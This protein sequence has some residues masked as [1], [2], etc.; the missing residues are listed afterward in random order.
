MNLLKPFVATFL[1]ASLTVSA[2]T[3][4]LLTEAQPPYAEQ[5]GGR[6]SGVA[7][8]I[9]SKLFKDVGLEY[10]VAIMPWKRAYATAQHFPNSCV[11]PVQRS[12]E[13]E[14]Q[15]HW[16]SPILITLTAFFTNADSTTSIRTLN[17]VAKLRIGSYL[18]SATA[19][20][21]QS[22]GFHVELTIRDEQNIH[23]LRRQRIDVWAT[24]ILVAN[25]LLRQSSESDSIKQRLAF[26]STLRGIACNKQVPIK[27]INRL[28]EQLKQM[29]LDG[30]IEAML[31]PYTQM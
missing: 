26:F 3:Y 27:V 24:D 28:S 5:S 25:Y 2:Q 18:G 7:V 22:Q 30:T 20:Y 19:Q 15:F 29:Y 8:D 13:R 23:K 31:K 14:S 9:V 6:I 10:K 4:T 16:V 12:Q 21:L 17:D 1:F 11:F